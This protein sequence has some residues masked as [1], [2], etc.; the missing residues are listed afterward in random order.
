MCQHVRHISWSKKTLSLLMR[1]SFLAKPGTRTSRSRLFLERKLMS[2]KT[3]FKRV[4][5]VAAAALAIGGLSAVSAHAASAG[6][7]SISVAPSGSTNNF[8]SGHEAVT[9]TITATA[10]T[11]NFIGL[12]VT[13]STSNPVVLSLTG[14]VATTSATTATGSGTASLLL[15]ANG[16][17]AVNVPT[18]TVGS[19]VVKTYKLTGGVQSTTAS[20]TLT[21]TV[22]AAA[23][24]VGVLNASAS[25]AYITTVKESAVTPAHVHNMWVNGSIS[26]GEATPLAAD[27]AV[28][29]AKGDAGTSSLVAGI[30]GVLNDSQSPTAVAMSGKTLTATISGSGLIAGN[31]TVGT[32]VG[33]TP[34]RVATTVTGDNTT[35]S[36]TAGEYAFNVNSDGTAGVGTITISYTDAT[37]VTTVVATKTVTFY[38]AAA[39]FAATVNKAYIEQGATTGT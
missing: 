21:I 18:P 16:D 30:Y 20:T 12:V 7:I 8:A 37:N 28:L 5:A 13:S 22:A 34:A 35:G 14:G 19:I 32:I 23:T 6:D 11:N 24:G 17:T 26:G 3:T 38:G 39:T 27:V 29:A 10:G 33:T 1:A 36:S 25:K 9:E 2:T 31:T 4:A 15:T